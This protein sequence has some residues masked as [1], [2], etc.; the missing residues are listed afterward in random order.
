MKIG[1]D[2]SQIV[3][4]GTGVAT[5]V[6]E[7]V[8]TLVSLDQKNEYVLFASSLRKQQTIRAYVEP[9]I[10]KY[11]NVTLKIFPFPPILLDIVWNRFHIIPIEWLIGPVD[12]Y[13][14]S[15]WSQPPLRKAK[16]MT[17]IHDLVV[18]KYPQET[19]HSSHLNV[20]TVSFSPNIVETQKR[21]LSWAVKECEIFLCDSEATKKDSMELLRIPDHQLMV[22]Y[23][24]L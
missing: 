15:D 3:Y 18:Y 9:I 4:E 6:R 11:S 7:I 23:P 8:S 16:G 22:V 17:T 13:W 19:A 24:G 10:T 5:Y 20:R 21:R 2:I 12:I 14:S 1:I